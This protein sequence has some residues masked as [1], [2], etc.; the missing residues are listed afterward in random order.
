MTCARVPDSVA[1]FF[2]F[3]QEVC[4][5]FEAVCVPQRAG[6]NG[7]QSRRSPSRKQEAARPASAPEQRPQLQTMP[8]QVLEVPRPPGTAPPPPLPLCSPPQRLLEVPRPGLPGSAPQLQPLQP[9]QGASPRSPPQRVLDMPR[10]G[11]SALQ[12]Q[13]LHPVASAQP[14][15]LKRC[16]HRCR[17]QRLC[18]RFAACNRCLIGKPSFRIAGSGAGGDYMTHGCPPEAAQHV[19]STVRRICNHQT[20]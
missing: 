4:R 9:S 7:R 8:P 14:A 10:R 18:P 5:I 20:D 16:P 3:R 1:S 12:P 13:L 17:L 19:T 11:G 2:V 15:W 6:A